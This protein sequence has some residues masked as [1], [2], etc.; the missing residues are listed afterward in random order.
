ML[1]EVQGAAT[2]LLASY[3]YCADPLE[4]AL[5]CLAA[6]A[7]CHPTVNRHKPNRLL[8]NIVRWTNC[9]IS[10]ESKVAVTVLIESLRE[11]VRM[12][13][14]RRFESGIADDIDSNPI[15]RATESLLIGKLIT[16]CNRLKKLAK[17][18]SQHDAVSLVLR[19]GMNA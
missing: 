19:I 4:P 12:L 13:R 9:G 2:L 11:V 10:N 5:T 8:G 15:Q 18:L 1:D 6:S 14:V 3:R 16:A 7:L 17:V